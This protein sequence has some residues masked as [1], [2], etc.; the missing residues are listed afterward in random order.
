MISYGKQSISHKDIKS[1][2]KVLKGNFLTQGP[3]VNNFEKSLQKYFKC[4][5]AIAVSSGTAALN[6]IS[7]FL[8]WK[9]DDL[10]VVSPITFLSS[11]NCILESKAK[12]Y[13]IDINMNDYSIDLD[14]LEKKLKKFKKKIKA[15]IVTDY[16]G[17]PA[18]WQRLYKLKKKYNLIL[19]N[20]NCHS[21]GSTINKNQGYACKFADF[22]SL[23]FHPVKNFTTGEGGAILTNNNKIS[24]MLKSLRSHGVTRSPALSKKFGPWYYEMRELGNNYRLS[25]IH[26][27]LGISQ[28]KRLNLFVKRRKVIA[29]FY[30]K[31]FC[32]RSKF[33]T[34]TIRKNNG[35]SFHLYPLLLN[36]NKIKKSKKEIFKEFLKNNI[37]LQV[38]YI[39]VNS[40]PFYKK[41]IPLNKKKYKNSFNFY[42]RQIS[43][44]IYFDLTDTQLKYIKKV[45]KKVFN[46]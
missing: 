41:L 5:N 31:L 17:H 21:M 38:H 15:I 45:C 30:N 13:F 16:A 6:L 35:H 25:D 32:D 39:P 37:R 46:I 43:M 22:V 27:A 20:D 8:K 4:N 18:D 29:S 33:T 28:I 24:N 1:V 7:K 2:T 42:E 11:A 23:S 36:L 3:S 12:P 14:I 44:P 19:I 26:A 34:P 10:I 9:K 40:Q